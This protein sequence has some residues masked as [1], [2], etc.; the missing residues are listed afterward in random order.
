[1]LTSS[2]TKKQVL[3]DMGRIASYSPCIEQV[4]R[5]CE[6]LREEGFSEITTVEVLVR[7]WDMHKSQIDI[8]RFKKIKFKK[9]KIHTY[10]VI[11]PLIIDMR[12]TYCVRVW[13]RYSSGVVETYRKD[14]SSRVI[15]S[16]SEPQALRRLKAK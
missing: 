1:M 16:M 5:T 8:P 9:L 15:E 7:H 14:Y 6:A 2:F 11:F 12:P 13:F 3:R 10:I 4:Q